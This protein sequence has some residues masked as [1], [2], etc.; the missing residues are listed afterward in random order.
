MRPLTVTCSAHN[1][2]VGVLSIRFG[3]LS[4]E[5]G[6]LRLEFDKYAILMIACVR[7]PHTSFCENLNPNPF[8]LG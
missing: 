1:F 8:I 2:E 7:Q 4:L 3:F 5:M 6:V